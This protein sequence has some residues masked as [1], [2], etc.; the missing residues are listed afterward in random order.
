MNNRQSQKGGRSRPSAFGVLMRITRVPLAPRN[1]VRGSRTETRRGPR[2]ARD[3]VS[4]SRFSPNAADSKAKWLS[5]QILT[6]ASVS[7]KSAGDVCPKR[8]DNLCR[9]QRREVHYSFTGIVVHGS[10]AHWLSRGLLQR[11]HGTSFGN[12]TFDMMPP[13]LYRRRVMITACPV[14]LL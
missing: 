13:F 3:V 12:A 4:C 11:A 10:G 8:N 5:A 6:R 7:W 14:T 1:M 2:R 9:S